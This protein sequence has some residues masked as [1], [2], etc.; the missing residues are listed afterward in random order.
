MNT[1]LTRPLRCAVASAMMLHHGM[2]TTHIILTVGLSE[3]PILVGAYRLC[4]L[5][6]TRDGVLPS[7]SALCIQDTT[8]EAARVQRALTTKLQEE[9]LLPPGGILRWTAFVVPRSNPAGISQ[10]VVNLLRLQP[11][12]SRVHLHYTGGSRALSVHALE[13][14]VSSVDAVGER[15]RYEVSY[16]SSG[17]DVLTW[18]YGTTPHLEDERPSWSLTITDLAS[19]NAFTPSSNSIYQRFDASDVP[20]EML[21]AAGAA[22]VP[23]LVSGESRKAYTSWLSGTWDARWQTNGKGWFRWPQPPPRASWPRDDLPWVVLSPEAEWAEVTHSLARCF[24]GDSVWLE[25]DAGRMLR[26][27]NLN[28]QDLAR[29]HQFLHYQCLELLAHGALKTSLVDL[30]YPNWAV[31]HS[32]RFVRQRSGGRSYRDF[33]LDVL[34]VLGYQLLAVSCS[35]ST[36]Q[37]SLKRKAFE[38]LHRAKQIGGSG[39]RTVLICALSPNEASTLLDDVEEDTGPSEKNLD[40]WGIESLT[41]LA[42]R[43]RR[44][45]QNR[46]HVPL[47]PGADQK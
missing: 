10:A 40:I 17:E 25:T 41:R 3:V 14:I 33:E 47:R 20:D 35:F 37:P 30:G 12:G 19:L 45:L 34:A 6:L 39:A 26:V 27:G 21:V 7:F 13:A 29:L 1:C 24:G 31:H 15:Y 9:S 18:G 5:Y 38:V 22:M 23:L 16:L 8:D 28:E 32:V 11:R 42:E 44:Y 36:D 4:R 46:L 43:F 2:P